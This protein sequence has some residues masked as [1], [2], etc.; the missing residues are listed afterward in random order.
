MID[1]PVVVEPP[2]VKPP[3]VAPPVVELP[4]EGPPVTEPPVDEPVDEPTNPEPGTGPEPETPEEEPPMAEPTTPAK[5]N[6]QIK[7]VAEAIDKLADDANIQGL[8]KP[9]LERIPV[10]VRSGIYEAG[11]WLGLVG[12]AGLAVAGVLSGEAELYAGSVSSLLLAVSNF[13]AKANLAK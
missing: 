8:A 12:A 3:V 4:V 5:P 6:E 1:P 11:K 9:S 10:K 2:V 13:V 7:D